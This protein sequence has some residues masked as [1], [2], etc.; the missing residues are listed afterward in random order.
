MSIEPNPQVEPAA[1]VAVQAPPASDPQAPTAQAALPEVQEAA[2]VETQVEIQAE[3]PAEVLTEPPSEAPVATSA[4][5]TPA[6]AQAKAP[7][8]D[9]AAVAALLRQHFPAL[10]SGPAKPIKLHI[11][12]D[13]QARAPGLV[14]KRSLSGFLHRYTGS[15]SYLIG[16][17]KATQRFDLDGQ[18]AGELTTEHRDLAAQEVARRRGLQ[19]ERRA[20]ENQRRAQDRQ[21]QAQ[22]RAQ[23]QGPQPDSP[24]GGESGAQGGQPRAQDGEP[25]AQGQAPE[26]AGRQDRQ[27]RHP[28]PPQN[29]RSARPPRPP[30]DQRDLADPRRQPRPKH[31]PD[32]LS[33][34]TPGN[35]AEAADAPQ[36]SIAPAAQPTPD[37][38]DAQRAT[39]PQRPP[40][41]RPRR[42]QEPQLGAEERAQQALLSQQRFN[43][44]GLLRDFERTTLTTSNFCVLK[45]VAVAELDGLLDI[46]RRERAEA[47]PSPPPEPRRDPR[48]MDAR[49]PRGVDPRG[50][51]DA[52]TRRPSGR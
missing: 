8:L 24:G 3:A 35:A 7:V 22:A 41:Q 11:Q 48:G 19:D 32:T 44:A 52:D 14:T 31:V 2:V 37:R 12:A 42:V 25:G 29:P 16:L 13:I 17:C 20:L 27:D 40:D 4:E 51:R 21:A 9:P 30:R 28:R 50:P 39:G 45:G 36:T 26:R 43:R 38:T 1:A 10:F 6:P 49:S 46:A 5:V 23:V 34:S 15:T 18:P 33:A 47:P